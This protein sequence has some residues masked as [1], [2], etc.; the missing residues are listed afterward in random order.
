MPSD[1]GIMSNWHE[2]QTADA[3]KNW[4]KANVMESEDV[5]S[6]RLNVSEMESLHLCHCDS[7][8]GVW[9]WQVG[10]MQI[11]SEDTSE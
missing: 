5:V 4:E 9:C 6:D 2:E 10:S 1:W 11:W 3:N 8:A 7:G